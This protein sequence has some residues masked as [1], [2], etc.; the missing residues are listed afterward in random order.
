MPAAVTVA[1]STPP[2]SGSDFP[3]RPTD[4]RDGWTCD[5]QFFFAAMRADVGK[6]SC[7]VLWFWEKLLHI[8]PQIPSTLEG[9]SPVSR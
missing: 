4:I 2:S 7:F 8:I 9:C 1:G 5:V 6:S 3:F